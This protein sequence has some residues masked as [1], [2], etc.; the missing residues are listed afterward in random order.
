M[1][2]GFDDRV[3]M[4]VTPAEVP[5]LAA[6]ILVLMPP[7]PSDEPALDT[8]RGVSLGTRCLETKE[9][10]T[11][12]VNL[13]DIWHNLNGL[14]IRICPG[15][16]VIQAVYVCHEEEVIGVDH[17]GGNC[18]EG[19]VVTKLDF[20]NGQGIVLIDNGDDAHVQER[21]ECVLGVEIP[22]PLGESISVR[23]GVSQGLLQGVTY[24]CDIILGEKN[25]GNWLIHVLEKAVPET[26]ESALPNCS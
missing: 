17:G 14:G 11:I 23:S 21:V 15:I 9:E 20:R 22:R 6:M 26:H 19:I 10:H 3:M 8:G 13:R 4:T 1:L 7:V 5:S 16:L 24:V 2:P 25:L 18:R 12:G